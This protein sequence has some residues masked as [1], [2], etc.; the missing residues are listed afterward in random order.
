[1]LAIQHWQHYALFIYRCLQ[2]SIYVT[3]MHEIAILTELFIM[4]KK[5]MTEV[6]I[7]SCISW[8]Y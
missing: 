1:M 6:G 2:I 4:E 3:E 5:A 7:Y 8:K